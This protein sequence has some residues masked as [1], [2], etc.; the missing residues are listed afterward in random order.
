MRFPAA[1]EF[2]GRLPEPMGNGDPV[3]RG[4]G[5]ADLGDKGSRSMDSMLS[6]S[7]MG[8]LLPSHEAILIYSSFCA[9][10]ELPFHGWRHSASSASQRML[11]AR[12]LA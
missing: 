6:G 5:E 1:G 3:A 8:I 4:Y 9:R 7:F 11:E 12:R 2:A 10:W